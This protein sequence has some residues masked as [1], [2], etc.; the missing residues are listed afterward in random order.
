MPSANPPSTKPLTLFLGE[1]D[2]P[3]ITDYQLGLFVFKLYRE[4]KY[5][6]ETI[7]SSATVATKEIFSK[8]IK[9]LLSTGVITQHPNF[10]ENKVFNI[11]GKKGYE[12]GDVCCAIDPFAY[13]SHLSAMSYHGLTDRIPSTLFN[14]RPNNK[15]WTKFAQ[16]KMQRDLKEDLEMYI[17]NLMPRLSRYKMDRIG[18]IPV[19]SYSSIHLG[20]YKNIKGRSLR[21]S[22]IGR[23]FLDMVR[24]PN[25]CG[26]MMHVVNVFKEYGRK[27]KALIIDEVDQ[28]GKEIEKARIGFLLEIF[29]G[30]T[31]ET[32]NKWAMKVQRGGSR[33][34]DPNNEFEPQYSERWCISLNIPDIMVSQD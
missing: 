1:L 16:Q 12:A 2:Q 23:T 30:V 28:H 14:T 5:N 29:A 10:P 7:K 20:A 19:S 34:L 22:S 3:V 31:D 32:L 15:D 9:S 4:R 18:K 24:E 21:V 8:A 25:L 27:Y 33:K 13:V 11:T 6:G 26:G 17:E